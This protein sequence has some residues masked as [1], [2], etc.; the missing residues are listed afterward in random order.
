M[1]EVPRRGGG[2]EKSGFYYPSDENQRFS[3]APLTRGAK[4]AVVIRN[5]AINT[6]LHIIYNSVIMY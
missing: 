5:S 1:R 6:N 4:G 2:R 3:P